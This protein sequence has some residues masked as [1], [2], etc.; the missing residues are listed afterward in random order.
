MDETLAVQV[1]PKLGVVLLTGVKI[2][3]DLFY[4]INALWR[5]TVDHRP[6]ED[7]IGP[8]EDPV[9]VVGKPADVIGVVNEGEVDRQGFK[10]R[11]Q[12]L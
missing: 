7:G 11:H 10:D 9:G 6:A 8:R 12:L 2:G 4:L 1:D 5:V 3:E